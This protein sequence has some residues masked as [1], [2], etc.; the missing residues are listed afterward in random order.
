MKS[1]IL[2]S[3]IILVIF[4]SLVLSSCGKNAQDNQN[5]PVDTTKVTKAVDST[6]I[7][8]SSVKATDTTAKP[9]DKKP[10]EKPVAKADLKGTWSGTF[11]SRTAVLKITSVNGNSF[12][13]SMTIHYR[14]VINQQVS[15]TFNSAKSSVSMKDLAHSKQ[16]GTYYAKLNSN[17]N[18]MSGTFTTNL[19]KQKVSFSLK[20]K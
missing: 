10:V 7:D 11:D 3:Y 19:D 15:G 2:K 13:G 8:T 6:A 20:K 9:E 1:L 5:Q 14:E 16:M 17:L 18:S 4:A 12:S